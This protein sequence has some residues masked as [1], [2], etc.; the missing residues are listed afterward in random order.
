M[1]RVTLDICYSFKQT[2]V[3]PFKKA[4]D[5]QMTLWKENQRICN[6]VP[7]TTDTKKIHELRME[8]LKRL[9]LVAQKPGVG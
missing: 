4:Y 2:S 9:D 5:T 7:I 6:F 8:E 3:G 1:P